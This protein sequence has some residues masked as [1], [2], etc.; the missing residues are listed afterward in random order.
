MK[1]YNQKKLLTSK[2]GAVNNLF[3]YSVKES[4]ITDSKV[5]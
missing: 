3:G 1:I 4:V 2:N 5:G